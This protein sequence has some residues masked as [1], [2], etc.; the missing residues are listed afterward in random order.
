M[1]K[2]LG[3]VFAI[4]V[5][6]SMACNM[7][8][9]TQTPANTADANQPAAGSTS[10]V[11]STPAAV[12]PSDTPIPTLTATPVKPTEVPSQPVGIKEGLAS[13]NSYT[14][15]ITMKSS[16]PDQK[17]STNITMVE[18]HSTDQDAHLTHYTT[19][20]MTKD[21]S[22]PTQGE[23][24]LYSIGSDSCSG[25]KSDWTWQSIPANEKE[26]QDIVQDMISITPVIQ[27]PTL[28]GPETVN[29][30]ATNHFTFKI[31]GLGVKSGAEVTSNQGE[32]WLALDGRYIVKYSLVMETRTGAN[33][34]ILHEELSIE[35][36]D[37]NQ[38]VSIAFPQTCLDVKKASP[39]PSQ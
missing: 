5:I 22:E 35:L 3:F 8:T 37:I 2:Q 30:I 39:T 14:L 7:S 34:N 16:G 12:Q 24:Y 1:K 19:Y 18:Q 36:T 21:D 29:G 17:D 10:E 27:N 15:T 28:V 9:S 6:L 33:A 25:S 38:P 11:V 26:M 31:S 20:M 4:L 23:N 13:L 32:Y